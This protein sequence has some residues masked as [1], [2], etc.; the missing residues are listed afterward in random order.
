MKRGSASNIYLLY[1][2]KFSKWFMLFMPIIVIFFQEN[3]LNMQQIFILKSLN[4]ITVVVME[5]PSGYLADRL[6]RRKTLLLGALLS[7]GGFLAYSVAHDFFMFLVAELFIG[8]SMS[9]I[10]GADSAMLYDSLQS[11]ERKNDYAKQEGRITSLGNFS[12]AAAGILGGFL[13]G[14]SLR[15]PF[16]AQTGIAFIGIPAALMLWEPKINSVLQKTTMLS[17]FN[18]MRDTFLRNRILRAYILFSAFAGM[19]TLTLAWFIQPY[20]KAIDLPLKWF[21]VLWTSLNISVALTA[22]WAYKAERL[23]SARM[24]LMCISI[25]IGGGFILLGF[26][27][28]VWGII[29]LFLIYLVR[30]IATPVLKDY[31]NRYTSSDV[32]ATI[33]SVRSFIIRIGFAVISPFLGW[34]TDHYDLQHALIIAGS[35]FLFSML[36]VIVV[37][38]KSIKKS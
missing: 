32:R 37:F 25:F 18:T 12:E 6:G 10:S 5:I 35:I 9:F 7:F 22:L 15:L 13:A 30:G 28:G 24:M 34:Y 36:T 19:T 2:L 20:F 27:E 33:L 29:V 3:G 4:A 16:I 23:I 38:W 26:F 17:V 31:I 1:I 14:I 8:L 21:G 11:L